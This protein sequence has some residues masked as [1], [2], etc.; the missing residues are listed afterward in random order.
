LKKEKT[1]EKLIKEMKI[2]PKKL[3]GAARWEIIGML[4]EFASQ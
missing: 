1:K 4:R 3:E 2:D